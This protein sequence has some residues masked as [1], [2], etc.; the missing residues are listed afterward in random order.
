[1]FVGEPPTPEHV[2]E[3]YRDA[4]LL[5]IDKP[6]G[7]PMHPSN[8]YLHGTVVG[9]L[10][11]QYGENFAAAVHRL[12]RETSG[13]V[14][15][16]RHYLAARAM[17]KAFMGGRVHKEYLTVAEGS[18]PDDD[19]TV[20]APIAVGGAVVRIATRVDFAEGKPART[21]FVREQ[22]F[23]RDGTPFV[24]LR[25]FPETGRRHQ[26]RLHVRHAGMRVVGD[27]IYGHDENFYVRF[28]EMTLG[29][30]DWAR[31]RL[32]RHALHAAAIEFPHPD[33]GHPVR[34]E[35]PLPDDLRR[36]VSP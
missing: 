1:M 19:F 35:S 36:F 26:V 12:D 32:Q 6:A 15:C 25:A 7:L 21:R 30:D 31:L 33:D 16:A 14:V 23:S 10:R 34:F 20:D 28:C 9:R 24:V 29:A 17:G 5:V 2:R 11:A 27:K 3:I 13:V 4:S 18:A 22:A 8:R